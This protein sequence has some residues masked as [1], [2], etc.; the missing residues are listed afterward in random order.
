MVT[1]DETAQVKVLDLISRCLDQRSYAVVIADDLAADQETLL[2]PKDIELLCAPFY[3]RAVPAI[4]RANALAFLHSCG[5]ITQLIPLIKAW[6]LDGLASVQHRTNDLIALHKELGSQHVIMAG[7]DAELL[8]SGTSFAGCTQR[9][10]TYCDF[11]GAFGQ[12]GSQ[13]Q[14]RPLQWKFSRAHPKYLC[15][16]RPSHTDLIRIRPY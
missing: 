16:C 9:I 1:A 13:L 4:H 2:S 7:I 8:E 12:P 11:P 5:K 6:Q 3:T 15:R 14:L 10:R